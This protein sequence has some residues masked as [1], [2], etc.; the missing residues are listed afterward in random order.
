[1]AAPEP[2]PS[3]CHLNNRRAVIRLAIQMLARKEALSD[4]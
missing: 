2:G 1:M 3:L 4:G